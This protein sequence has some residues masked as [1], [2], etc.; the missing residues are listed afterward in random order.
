M[1]VLAL[2]DVNAVTPVLPALYSTPAVS[3]SSQ[4]TS[5][6]EAPYFIYL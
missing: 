6:S 3:V 5:F 4:Q 2:N 1:V